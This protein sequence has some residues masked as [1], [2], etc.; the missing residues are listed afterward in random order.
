MALSCLK[1]PIIKWQALKREECILD[2]WKKYIYLV[3]ILT[4][5]LKGGQNTLYQRTDE[6]RR[7]DSTISNCS[8]EFCVLSKLHGICY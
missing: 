6:M 7:E 5:K 1:T 2:G 4:V 3:F 8:N